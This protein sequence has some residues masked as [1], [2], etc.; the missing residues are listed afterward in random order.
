METQERINLFIKKENFNPK[1]FEVC[2]RFKI[3]SV[4]RCPLHKDY[5]KLQ[6]DKN[7]KEKKCKVS[8]LIR[9]EISLHFNLKNRGLT[10]RELSSLRLSMEMK[11]QFL[12]TKDKNLKLNVLPIKNDIS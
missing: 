12:I 10:L 4:N 8:K 7:D 1:P 11:P 3:C 5:N 9:K 6:I 2:P